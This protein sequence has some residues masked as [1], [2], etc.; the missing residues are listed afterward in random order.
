MISP[1]DLLQAGLDRIRQVPPEGD[2]WGTAPWAVALS[3]AISLAATSRLLVGLFDGTRD[4][5]HFHDRAIGIAV[6]EALDVSGYAHNYILL[7]FLLV[8]T[9]LLVFPL[10]ALVHGYI[11]KRIDSE[12]I[13]KENKGI[14]ILSEFSIALTVLSLIIPDHVLR[15]L[16]KVPF[17]LFFLI[18]LLFVLIFAKIFVNRRRRRTPHAWP[19]VAAAVLSDDSLLIA[20]LLLPF[21]LLF[22]YWVVFGR[23]LSFS[24]YSA[25]VLVLGYLAILSLGLAL[26][27]LVVYVRI[28]GKDGGDPAAPQKIRNFHARCIATGIPLMLIPISAPL[29]NELQYRLPNCPPRLPATIF[30]A[31][32]IIAGVLVFKGCRPQSPANRT[33]LLIHAVY[34]PIFL[35]TNTLFKAHRQVLFIGDLDY[36]H[37]GE[38]TLPTQQLFNFGSIPLIDIRLTHTFSDM[39][40]QTLYTWVNGYHGMDM[41]LWARW[42]PVVLVI[43]LTYFFLSRMTSP[44]FALLVTS[45]MPILGV[46]KEYYTFLFVPALFLYY[47][48]KQPGYGRFLGVWISSALLFF[49]RVDFGLTGLVALVLVLTAFGSRASFRHL[50]VMVVPLVWVAGASALLLG[51]LVWLSDR[52]VV[53]TLLFLFRTYSYRLI[54]RTRPT[55]I[56]E[57]GIAAIFQYYLLPAVSWIYLGYLGVRRVLKNER[58]SPYKYMLAFL[59]AFSLIISTRSLERHSLIEGFNPYLF[60]FLW[61]LLPFMVAKSRWLEKFGRRWFLAVL[62]LSTMFLLQPLGLGA[63]LKM[64]H[65]AKQDHLFEFHQW[66]TDSKRVFFHEERHRGIVDFLTTH[67]QGNETFFDFSNAP[68]LYVLTNKEFPTYVIPNLNQTAET[69]QNRVIEELSTFHEQGRLP[70]VVFK[71]GRYFWDTTDDVPNEIRCYRIAE[72]VYRHYV[73]LV[74]IDGYEVWLQRGR[75]AVDLYRRCERWDLRFRTNFASHNMVKSDT[76]TVERV[77]FQAG[78]SDPYVLKLLDLN[79]V[80]RLKQGEHWAFRFRYES[81]TSGRMQMFL[82]KNREDFSEA[83]SIWPPL[84]ETEPGEMRERFIPLE[85]EEETMRLTDIRFDPPA[86]SRFGLEGAEILRCEDSIR[87]LYPEQVVQNFPLRKLPYVWGAYDPLDASHQTEI[88]EELNEEPIALEPG[89]D[90]VLALPA[91]IDK[92]LGNYLH[93]R[94]HPRR[95][96]APYFAVDEDATVALGYGGLFQSWIEMNIVP[97]RL[98]DLEERYPLELRNGYRADSLRVDRRWGRMVLSAGARSGDVERFLQLDHLPDLDHDREWYLKLNYRSWVDTAVGVGFEFDGRGFAEEGGVIELRETARHETAREILVPIVLPATAS[99][100]TDVRI[101][102]PKDSIVEIEEAWIRGGT[103]GSLDYL[104]RLSTQWKWM[105]EPIEELTLR[106]SRPVVIERVVLRKGD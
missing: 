27:G 60:V 51:C 56:D 44:L 105:H 22:T 28:L 91:E 62:L 63:Y 4:L 21:P 82:Q 10:T 12:L 86:S 26:H 17:A 2:K 79:A 14:L 24:N 38:T 77:V 71:Q 3:A 85:F 31:I 23:P 18:A 106:S 42:M 104:I 78:E 25:P 13:R 101:E 49:W 80:P 83:G 103:L 30:I 55:V 9:F 8:A 84:Q 19:D 41:L 36:F 29:A 61:A 70:Y 72:F 53:E 5:T 47:A 32:L 7:N 76:E 16:G 93:L 67:L 40:Y 89:E 64:F 54:T 58:F 99:R 90:L 11:K 75:E 66:D 20:G 68:L 69:V 87:P 52:P 100:L 96:G 59:A 102:L 45:L 50:K 97:Y 88:L 73:P 39:F 35:A 43:V 46:V 33:P 94:L 98:S 92:S 6:L 15:N 34:L 95:A 74:A 57:Y 48:L 1:R 65:V 81:S 37:L